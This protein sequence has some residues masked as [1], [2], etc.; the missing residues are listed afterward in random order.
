[1]K[2]KTGMPKAVAWLLAMM[3]VFT[4]A[5]SIAFAA[6]ETPENHAPILKEG[7]SDVT[8]QVGIGEAYLL[9][10]LQRGNI[11]E[12]P[13]GDPLYVVGSGAQGS[14]STCY[15]Y[16]RSTD[17]GQTWGSVQSFAAA[18]FGSTTISLSENAAG[19]YNYRFWADDGKENGSSADNGDYWNLTLVVDEAENLDWNMRFFLGQ[20]HNFK[21]NGGVYP[22]IRMWKSDGKSNKVGD[23]IEFAEG[24]NTVNDSGY[25]VF[26]AE[27]KGGWYVYEAYSYNTETGKCD[28]P[29]GGMQLKLP[30]DKN[31]DGN[32]AGGSDIYL[33]EYATYTT[34]KKIDGTYF[35]AEDY[36]A[37]MDCPIMKCKA[38]PGEAYKSGN[39]S[40]YPFYVYAG[41]NACLY[42]RYVYPTDTD[43]YMFNQAINAT[44]AK[45]TAAS[46]G[47]L[48]INQAME[49]TVTVPQKADFGLY[50]QFNNFNTCEQKPTVDWKDNDDNTK[51]AVYRVSKQNSNYTWRL[52]DPDG[53]KVTKAGWLTQLKEAGSLDVDFEKSSTDL[54]SHSFADLGT[55]TKLRDEGDIQVNLD[56]TGAKTLKGETRVRAYR[57][58]ELI[59]SD[60]ANIM[61]EPDFNWDVIDGKADITYVDETCGKIDGT[62]IDSGN[63]RHNWADVKADG[64]GVVAVTYD[65][66]DVDVSNNA[67]H[68]GFYPATNPDRTSVMV[69]TDSKMGE[70]AAHVPFNSN[71]SDSGRS[72]EWDYIYDTWY[73]MRGDADADL[74]FTA[75]KAQKVEYAF[76][77]T[78]DALKSRM[79]GY[80]TVS[81]KNGR[82]HV[83]LADFDKAENNY[84]GTVIIRMTDANGDYSYQLVK[85]AG[86][87]V[88]VKNKSFPGEKVMPGN[89]V[90]VTFEGTY[91]SVNKMSGIFNPTTFNM[92]YTAGNEET[93]GTIGQYQRLDSASID[94]TVPE[95]FKV[96]GESSEYKFTN[97]YIF[98]SMYSAANPFSTIY[99][100]TDTG[101]G[102]NFNAVTV[103]WCMQHL[104]DI[105]I[106][107]Y[108]KATCDVDFA[109]E[110][111]DSY[112]LEVK[113]SKGNVVEPEDG[114]YVLGYGTYSYKA[115]ADGFIDELGKFDV[116]SKD[117]ESKTVKVTLREATEDTWDGASV[118][119][120]EQKDGVYQIGTGAQ[121]AW[122]AAQVNSGAG[123]SYKAEL[124]KDISLG[125]KVWSPIGTSSTKSFK[126]MFDGQ[127]HYVTDLNCSGAG[128]QGLFGYINAATVKNLG[129]K[130]NVESTAANA[131]GI[132]GFVSGKG[133][134]DNCVNYA[135]VTVKVA[136]GNAT[137]GGI[138]GAGGTATISNCFNAGEITGSGKYV[139]GINGGVSTVSILNNC[140]NIGK[141]TSSVTANVGALTGVTTAAATANNSYYLEGSCEGAV[142]RGEAK[143]A[144]ELKALA[145][146]L[147]DE[148]CSD[149]G[150]INKG[151]PI[152]KWQCTHKGAEF[153][154]A[155]AAT[156]DQDGNKA[157]YSCA[158]GR[159][160]DGEDRSKE[161]K[162]DRWI[163]PSNS[164]AIKKLKKD[165]SSKVEELEA[166]E[167]SLKE[168]GA[169][170]STIAK[171]ETMISELNEMKTGVEH[172]ADVLKANEKS[173]TDQAE[174]N[175]EMAAANEKLAAENASLL[176]EIEQKTAE[177]SDKTAEIE[178]IKKDG[179]ALKKKLD[180]ANYKLK[181]ANIR[182][183][184][185]SS[186]LKISK[187]KVGKRSMTVRYKTIS[188]AGG[189]QLKYWKAGTKNYHT[190]TVG[191]SGT[192]TIKK[193]VKGKKYR[194][195][196]RAYKVFDGK[197]IYGNWSVSVKSKK[198]K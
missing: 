139:G 136:S 63:G 77:T 197:K 48:A 193:L 51:T 157:Y 161:I 174:A 90:N 108:K 166:L 146:K 4:M 50:F 57:W 82:Y 37:S 5:P 123:A 23:E 131:A 62:Q 156:Y 3:L 65:A 158:C 180:E 80:K 70:A 11:F 22:E 34:S 87:K 129:V 9:S 2:K 75:D 26:Y 78:N 28:I 32:A 30:T 115:V 112:T 148:F 105:S 171:I 53:K 7:V 96:E 68:G 94:L 165:I 127:G 194:V 111:S 168:S 119:E 185:L 85:V 10:D 36:T 122:F 72:D 128:Y 125:N 160:F 106:D 104:A 186:P 16:Q 21:T 118:S 24:S 154:E 178:K 177:I 73:Y 103:S 54:K 109:V 163:E 27:L 58:W 181:K 169:E 175:E 135:D 95:D 192:K 100:M 52:T 173:M 102:T 132:I 39:Y 59:N 134:I 140:Y 12:D 47:S 196:V 153:H 83:S 46:T 190:I 159:Y 71:G 164:G 44:V 93:K 101:V 67:T 38:Q 179:Q 107:V 133:V 66:L 110:G 144:E 17:G 43:N 13:D 150:N 170:E 124:T 84:G 81:E 15:F 79:S 29:L 147:S 195:K 64:T 188:A 91:R 88:T 113:D 89:T 14:S 69:V 35:G 99:G 60:T 55:V 20:D 182:I 126:G 45:G 25:N 1:M 137:A 6:D 56:P 121:L 162:K 98:G 172:I 76:V 42:N 152:L 143:T 198:I 183:A 116:K 187:I 114:K 117:G 191:K 120:P 86:M 176:A 138:T 61:I 184:L 130:G 74:F 31:V 145:A 19:T 155:K 141:I 40:Y 41:G 151:Y 33:R 149:D 92:Y 49:L 97:G 142:V 189:Y 18:L 8:A 167:E